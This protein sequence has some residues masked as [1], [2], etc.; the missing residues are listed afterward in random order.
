[1]VVIRDTVAVAYWHTITIPWH[2]YS[3]IVVSNMT[4]GIYLDMDL[5]HP[6]AL[7]M[8][9]DYADRQPSPVSEYIQ[10]LRRYV[11]VLKNAK[12]G[13]LIEVIADY[14]NDYPIV[15]ETRGET[16]RTDQ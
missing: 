15:E 1:M 7:V 16:L 4:N 10:E 12:D 11:D 2:V 5:C 9:L 6:H 8:S 13:H 3:V 14:S